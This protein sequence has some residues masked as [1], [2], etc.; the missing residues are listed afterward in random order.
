MLQCL[1]NPAYVLM[2]MTCGHQSKSQFWIVHVHILYIKFTSIYSSSEGEKHVRLFPSHFAMMTSNSLLWRCS[3]C[4]L[5]PQ[6][7]KRPE[8]CLYSHYLLTDCSSKNCLLFAS[9]VTSWAK[10]YGKVLVLLSFLGAMYLVTQAQ[11]VGDCY[12]KPGCLGD[13]VPG[14][15]FQLCCGRLVGVSYRP[16]G[17]SCLSW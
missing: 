6:H 14:Y 2:V 7:I 4:L 3:D 10:M 17:G 12:F 8:C 5:Y 9:A 1:A 16:L 13:S 15:S 11:V